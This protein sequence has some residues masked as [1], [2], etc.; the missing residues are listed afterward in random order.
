MNNQPYVAI[1]ARRRGVRGCI[2]EPA[3]GYTIETF[4]FGWRQFPRALQRFIGDWSP[5]VSPPTMPIA[6]CTDDPWPA[7][8]L[9]RLREEHRVITIDTALLGR[10]LRRAE[11]YLETRLPD[12]RPHLMAF[13]ARHD[14][15]RYIGSI[16]ELATAWA[17]Q[18]ARDQ[19]FKAEL[20]RQHLLEQPDP[21]EQLI[22]PSG[23]TVRLI[24]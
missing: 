19:L 5:Y 18:F 7:G 12:A 11:L 20:S 13:L 14:E 21:W 23:T 6:A 16:D 24:P 15:L 4:Q 2:A 22:L 1:Q 3:Y 10:V 17:M 8:V 9:D